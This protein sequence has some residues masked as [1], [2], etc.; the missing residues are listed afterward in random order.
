MKWKSFL[1]HK[2]M[3]ACKKSVLFGPVW[4]HLAT[5]QFQF[6]GISRYFNI[7]IRKGES[8]TKGQFFRPM[9]TWGCFTQLNHTYK[10]KSFWPKTNNISLIRKHLQLTVMEHT[11]FAHN[12]KFTA[13]CVA[14]SNCGAVNANI[15][16]KCFWQYLI[17]FASNTLQ[18]FALFG[19][20]YSELAWINFKLISNGGFKKHHKEG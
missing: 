8:T 20:G 9:E 2:N 13:K 1:P 16:S 7:S 12:K 19:L 18:T 3:S 5:F 4:P 6:Q 14:C 11:V 15:L 17:I 10:L